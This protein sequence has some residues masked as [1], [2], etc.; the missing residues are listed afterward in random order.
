MIVLAVKRSIH[1]A[2]GAHRHLR[3]GVIQS[4][5]KGQ[6]VALARGAFIDDRV[7]LGTPGLLIVECVVLHAGNHILILHAKKMLGGDHSSQIGVFSRCLKGPPVARLP[8]DQVNIASEIYIDAKGALLL[9]DH[10]AVLIGLIQIPAGGI[11]EGRRQRC[12]P[13]H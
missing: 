9:A 3:V 5:F 7:R 13:S 2:I 12:R 10:L 1:Q 6:Q 11:G 8:A 4:Y